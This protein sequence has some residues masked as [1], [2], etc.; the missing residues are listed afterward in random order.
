[1]SCEYTPVLS[2]ALLNFYLLQRASPQV[3]LA[4]SLLTSTSSSGGPSQQPGAAGQLVSLV[5]YG[6]LV[7]LP[8]AMSNGVYLTS[9]V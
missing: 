6:L 1:M 5:I 8:L 9:A 3:L 7:L 4:V 2:C